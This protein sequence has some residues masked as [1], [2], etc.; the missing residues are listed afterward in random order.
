VYRLGPAIFMSPF[1][2]PAGSQATLRPETGTARTRILF[3]CASNS[4]RSQMAEGWA[5]FLRSDDIEAWSAGIVKKQVDPRAVQ[6][7]A[8]A[9]VDIS[10]QYSKTISELPVGGFDFVITLC[11]DAQEACPVF[12]GRTAVVHHGFDDPPKLAADASSEEEALGHYR[13][14]M[15]EIREFVLTLP[16]SLEPPGLS[17]D[18]LSIS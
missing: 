1:D 4:C 15:N 2:E 9:G 3:L 18:I 12:P 14:V 6:V 11:S 10:A 8:E 17:L 13:R 16:G 7:M 5:R